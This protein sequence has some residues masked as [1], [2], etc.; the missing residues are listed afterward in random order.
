MARRVLILVV[1]GFL[2]LP[3]VSGAWPRVSGTWRVTFTP[4]NYDQPPVTVTW[5]IR[6]LCEFGACN[7]HVKSR[8]SGRHYIY[9]L[10]RQ[11]GWYR[12]ERNPGARPHGDCVRKDGSVVV[13]DAYF[14]SYDDTFRVTRERYGLPVRLKG[15][16]IEYAEPTGQG[17]AHDCRDGKFVDRIYAVRLGEVKPPS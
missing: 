9:R 5:R 13:H 16:A 1:L 15:T 10:D 11:F 2:G 12:W 7:L 8:S 3:S 6:P 4:M 17:R 14:D